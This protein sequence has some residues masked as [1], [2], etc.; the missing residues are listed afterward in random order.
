[1][2]F[3]E[4]EKDRN[5]WT[6]LVFGQELWLQEKTNMATLAVP[7]CDQDVAD[8]HFVPWS[9]RAASGPFSF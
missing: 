6:I 2:I 8:I 9:L 1:M 5:Y 3:E 4:K 7:V